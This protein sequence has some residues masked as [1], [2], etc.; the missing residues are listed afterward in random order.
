[1][2]SAQDKDY[3]LLRVV[4]KSPNGMSLVSFIDIFCVHK[5]GAVEPIRVR[6]WS[7]SRPWYRSAHIEL[8]AKY[9]PALLTPCTVFTVLHWL[10]LLSAGETHSP[11]PIS[12]QGSTAGQRTLSRQTSGFSVILTRYVNKWPEK[13]MHF[14]TII[15]FKKTSIFFYFMCLLVRQVRLSY[16]RSWLDSRETWLSYNFSGRVIQSATVQEPWYHR[17]ERSIYFRSVVKTICSPFKVTRRIIT[18]IVWRKPNFLWYFFTGVQ[19]A[20]LSILIE[21][22]YISSIILGKLFHPGHL[23]RAVSMRVELDNDNS[24]SNQLPSSYHVNH[25]KLEPGH[26]VQKVRLCFSIWSCCYSRYQ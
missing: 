6:P 20:L 16:Y 15:R 11:R 10:H 26:L 18:T 24:F 17:G 4:T 5:L 7:F 3:A 22:V 2:E 21:P 23:S 19:G 13:K 1:M 9:F 12:C 25:P 8:L 14:R